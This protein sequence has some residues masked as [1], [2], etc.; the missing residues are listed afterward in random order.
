VFSQSFFSFVVKQQFVADS[1]IAGV[2]TMTI[3][4]FNISSATGHVLLDMVRATGPD[5][6]TVLGS[7]GV[8]G[9]SVQGTKLQL[10]REFFLSL[11][12]LAFPLRGYLRAR[13]NRTQCVMP[14]EAIV[15]GPCF[16]IV[17]FVLD[18]ADFNPLCPD[19]IYRF[20]STQQ[21][22]ITWTEP[23]LLSVGGA[24]LALTR[25]HPPGSLFSEGTTS[26]TY[27][28]QDGQDTAQPLQTR[29]LCSFKV[30]DNHA[31]ILV[32]PIDCLL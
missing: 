32:A 6:R 17:P 19:D 23:K 22:G 9:L 4:D 3:A 2:S 26:I 5:N 8:V 11:S 12:T 24:T 21:Q 15:P 31:R 27:A 20:S 7:L 30:S 1:P 25:T 18:V 13:D 16:A 10:S 28:A 14:N 29:L